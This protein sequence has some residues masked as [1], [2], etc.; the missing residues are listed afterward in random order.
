MFSLSISQWMLV[1]VALMVG[2]VVPGCKKDDADDVTTTSST[3]P[4]PAP[5]PSPPAE[6]DLLN[7]K[8]VLRCLDII[9][10]EHGGEVIDKN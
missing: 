4:S 3:T 7:N 5:G 1:I 2:I 8:E 6:T 9:A 10:R